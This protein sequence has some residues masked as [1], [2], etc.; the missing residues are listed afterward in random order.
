MSTSAPRAE[1][2]SLTPGQTRRLVVGSYLVMMGLAGCIAPLAVCLTSIAQTF[3]DLTPAGLGL[4][5]TATLL[6]V[7]AAML[8]TGPLADRWGL[9]RFMLIG[10]AIQ[11]VALVLMAFSPTATA[12]LLLTALTGL[13]TGAEDALASPLIAGIQPANRTRAM[14]LLHACFPFGSLTMI[15]G[16]SALLSH[17]GTWRAVFPV[18]ALPTLAGLV[19]FAVTPFPPSEL[20][21]D[22]L[23]GARRLLKSGPFWVAL[24]GIFLAGATEL[25]A[26]H[27]MPA[28]VERLLGGSREAGARVYMGFATG[29]LVGRLSAGALAHRLRPVLLLLAATGL[30]LACLLVASFT[31]GVPAIAALVCLGLGVAPWW[32]TLLAYASDRVPEGGATMFSVLAALGNAG[33]A[34]APSVIGLAASYGTLR[35]GYRAAAI[36]PLLA[37]LLFA[38]RMWDR[39]RAHARAE[40]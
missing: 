11:A 31:G 26:T 32:P 29:M 1:A 22:P 33:G 10:A 17:F 25:G 28:Y 36:F 20:L 13:G 2:V 40:E 12:F 7:M 15:A 35:T 30:C 9:R 21:G 4:L 3:P 27:W 24:V 5:S 39:R 23:S 38:W 18:M 34:L 8:A 19:I 37:V 16:S 6:G 14:N